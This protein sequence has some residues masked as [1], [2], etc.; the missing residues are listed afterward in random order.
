MPF[1]CLPRGAVR[2]H[3]SFLSLCSLSDETI[4]KM[5]FFLPFRSCGSLRGIQPRRPPVS[6]VM[7]SKL[8]YAGIVLLVFSFNSMAEEQSLETLHGAVPAFKENKTELSLIPEGEA[9]S[10]SSYVFKSS[11]TFWK[12]LDSLPISSFPPYDLGYH[13]KPPHRIMFAS[14]NRQPEGKPFK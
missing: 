5:T 4:M 6:P 3:K 13:A 7:E 10:G 9:V 8:F 1:H 12:P 11:N 2:L 14:C